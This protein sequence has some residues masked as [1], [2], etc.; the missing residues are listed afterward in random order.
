MFSSATYLSLLVLITS[1][2]N[3]FK[4]FLPWTEHLPISEGILMTG[5]ISDFQVHLNLPIHRPLLNDQEPL[6]K[7]E[8][9][10]EA[11]DEGQSRILDHPRVKDGRVVV[12]VCCCQ[13]GARLSGNV[14]SGGCWS[15]VGVTFMSGVGV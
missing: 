13:D 5:G 2:V 1:T 7:D 6:V 3:C 4:V 14:A 12:W 15:S 11:E 10:R 9:E 8:H